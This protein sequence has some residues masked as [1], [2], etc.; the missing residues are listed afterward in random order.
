M[1]EQRALAGALAKARVTALGAIAHETQLLATSLHEA[2]RGQATPG[3]HRQLPM[4]KAGT[5]AHVIKAQTYRFGDLSPT[6][7]STDQTNIEGKRMD[8]TTFKLRTHTR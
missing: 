4:Q 7:P 3:E 8:R 2:L 1:R 6:L 5:F